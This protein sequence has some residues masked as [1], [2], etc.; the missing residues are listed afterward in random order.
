MVKAEWG[1]KR[2]CPDCG[3]K[4]YDFQKDHPLTCPA[5]QHSFVPEL[6]LR[7]R[8]SRVAEIEAE[9]V[10]D[11]DDVVEVDDD[12]EASDVKEITA[13]DAVMPVS[14]SSD[15]D[16]DEDDDGPDDLGVSDDSDDLDD[17]IIEDD[18]SIDVDLDDDLSDDFDE[19]NKV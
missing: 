10:N 17:D 7:S 13:E 1:T 5:C 18:D 9:D 8:R 14:G 12:E 11:E 19:D 6:L 4:F 3:I 16:D 2:V 15:L